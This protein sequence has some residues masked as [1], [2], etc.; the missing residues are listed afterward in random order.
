VALACLVV[1]GGEAAGRR[2]PGRRQAARRGQ[3]SIARC[4]HRL[5]VAKGDQVPYTLALV[6]GRSGPERRGHLG[7]TSDYADASPKASTT[8]SCGGGL[9]RLFDDHVPLGSEDESFGGCDRMCGATN[10]R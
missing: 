7:L 5:R 4:S 2:G 10:G 8:S 6:F 9:R 1:K 3:P